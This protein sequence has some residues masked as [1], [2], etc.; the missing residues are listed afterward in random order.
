MCLS[1]SAP[2]L[3][4]VQQLTTVFP[5]DGRAVPVVD[6]VSFEIQA[7]ETLGLV[8]ESGCGKSMTA[9]SILR[10]VQPPGRIAGG[11]V[12]FRGRSLLALS[13]REMRAVRGAEIALVAQEPGAA[14]NPVFTIGDQIAEVLRVHR[15]A[16]P[17]EARR[18]AVGLLEQVKLADPARG[19]DAYPHELSGGMQQRALIAM[20]LACR[21][22]LLI[23][24][25]P[26]TA[27]DVTIQAQV[28]DLLGEL[29][30]AYTLSVLLISHDLGI[31]AGRA[32]RVA[33]MY[34]GRIVEQAPVRRIFS[35]PT[36][37]YTRALLASVPRGAGGRL[38]AIEGSVPSLS[39]L[40]RGCSFAPR[41]PDAV[42]DCGLEKPA[43]VEIAAGH[44]V[45]CLVHG[46]SRGD[47][48]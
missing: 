38:H 20:A 31:I 44:T 35:A 7:G 18:L 10:L 12:G 11:H 37:P 30:D 43:S 36:H 15:R 3:L 33:V 21:P 6:D 9:L 27:L 42:P 14:L 2:P 5:V 32:D 13:E 48:S 46:R 39:D 25:E 41:C 40:P 29:R 16:G 45:R 34:A 22:S 8:G 19:A 1:M 24:D 4:E 23:A 17:S 28:L 26:T 47:S